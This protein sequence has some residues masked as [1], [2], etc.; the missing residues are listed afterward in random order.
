MINENGKEFIAK[1]IS[2]VIGENLVLEKAIPEL[3][4][5]FDKYKNGREHDL[6]IWGKTDSGK[7]IFIGIEAKVD[8]KFNCKI[9]EAY[10]VAKTS[11]LNGNKTNAPKRIEEI[12]NRSF[13]IIRKTHWNLMYQLF[14]TLF[15]TLDAKNNGTKA[16][17]P[18][19]FFIVFKTSS[20]KENYGNRNYK[21]YILF[22]SQFN[23]VKIETSRQNTDA[24]IIQIENKNLYSIYC[25]L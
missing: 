15:G 21:E 19:T 11:E 23:A 2:E 7:S 24:H 14:Y 6:G 12:L 5:R 10:V 16:D 25:Q 17:I 8:E 18:I 22:M 1:Q 4:T 9:S 3:E 20:Y 13:Q